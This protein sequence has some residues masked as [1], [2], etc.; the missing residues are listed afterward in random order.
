MLLCLDGVHRNLWFFY[1]QLFKVIYNYLLY[2]YLL[3]LF[4]YL[5]IDVDVEDN[6]INKIT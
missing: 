2:I 1:L 4:T 6:P 3:Y 5:Y